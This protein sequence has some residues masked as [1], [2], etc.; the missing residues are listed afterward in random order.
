MQVDGIGGFRHSRRQGEVLRG[1]FEMAARV[2]VA[3]G[4]DYRRERLRPYEEQIT[5]AFGP[6]K[7]HEGA[8][9]LVPAAI[10]R[11]LGARLLA[12]RAFVRRVV[13]DRW[14]LRAH[15]TPPERG[16]EAFPA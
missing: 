2:I 14:F 8:F 3:A 7:P 16:G 5:A 15:D 6:R 10:R 12:R 11:F 1:R 4:G 9:R 13:L